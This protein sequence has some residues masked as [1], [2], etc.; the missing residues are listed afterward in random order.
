MQLKLKRPLIFFDVETTG[1]DTKNDRI[2]ELA[3]IK[4]WPDGRPEEER[5]R[6]FNPLVPIPKEAAAIHGI[7]NEDVKDEMPFA[8]YARGEQ[9]IAAFFAGS[10]LAGFNIVSFD[11]PILKAELE[12]AGERLD[13]RDVAVIDAF[14]IFTSKEPRNL[15]AAVKLYCNKEIENAHSAIGDVTATIDVFDAQ[16]ERYSDLPDEPEALDRAMRHPDSVDRAGKLRWV[17]DEVTVAFGRNKGRTLKYLAREE[18]DYVR[19]MIDNEVV[20]DAES[21][22]RDALV[23]HF[24]SPPKS[25]VEASDSDVDSEE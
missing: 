1:L 3:A 5:V 20:P 16:L 10:D 17:D 8:R 7:T 21:C 13:L 18:S 15:T 4:Y 14:K 12:R 11:I 24:A 25:E 2:V 19:W 22:L 6:R 9:G 23:G